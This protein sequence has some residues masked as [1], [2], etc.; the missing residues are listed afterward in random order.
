METGSTISASAQPCRKSGTSN[1]FNGEVLSERKGILMETVWMQ[2][3][4]NGEPDPTVPPKEVEAKPEV[5][6]PLMNT[7][8]NQCEAPKVE[9][10]HNA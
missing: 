1:G 8:W 4:A 10:Q 6:V 2:K 9:E 3:Y 7:G 5:L